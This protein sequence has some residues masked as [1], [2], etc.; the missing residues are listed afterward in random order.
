MGGYYLA[1]M[2]YFKTNNTSSLTGG[3][4]KCTSNKKNK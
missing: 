3:C 4:K 1:D 2:A